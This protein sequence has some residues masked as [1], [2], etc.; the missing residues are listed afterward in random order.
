MSDDVV[1]VLAQTTIATTIAILLVAIFRKPLA[2]I[3]GARVAYLLWV[4]VPAS[5]LVALLPAPA[6][7]FAPV[8]EIVPR[9]VTTVLPPAASSTSAS[10]RGAG[11]SLTLVVWIA[12]AALMLAFTLYR[13]RAFLRSLGTTT[14]APDGTHRSD[15]IRG[16]V[17]VGLWKPRIVLPTDFETLY[18]PEERE[19]VLAHE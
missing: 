9:I 10:P 15:T 7:P 6:E 13:Q 2:R 3:A 4:L 18:R 19:L 5:N 12:G 14:V 17:L 16:P 8:Q 1:Y 11:Y